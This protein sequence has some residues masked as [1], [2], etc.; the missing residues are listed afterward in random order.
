MHKSF[1]AGRHGLYITQPTS[2]PR[3]P[4]WNYGLTQ[5]PL[6]RWLDKEKA[7]STEGLVGRLAGY[8]VLPATPHRGGPW[9]GG[10]RPRNSE[11]LCK[12]FIIGSRRG[13]GHHCFTIL[14]AW[15]PL[16]CSQRVT[17]LYCTQTDPYQGSKP[18]PGPKNTSPDSARVQHNTLHAV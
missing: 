15:K 2:G 6:P 12:S 8:Y 9:R 10:T 18:R 7:V 3:G 11:H 5:T 13:G 14:V 4:F 1:Q 17:S 16:L